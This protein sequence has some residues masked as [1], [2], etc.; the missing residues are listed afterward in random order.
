[1]VLGRIMSASAVGCLAARPWSRAKAVWEFASCRVRSEAEAYTL[2]RRGP[3]AK[4]KERDSVLMEN[5]ALGLVNH[6][7]MMFSPHSTWKGSHYFGQLYVHSTLP[8]VGAAAG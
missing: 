1:M 2:K 7:L 4:G 3:N 6:S 8:T 5:N